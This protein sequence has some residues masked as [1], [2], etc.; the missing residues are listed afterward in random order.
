M[1]F[2]DALRRSG[3]WPDAPEMHPE[4]SRVC[5]VDIVSDETISTII[6]AQRLWAAELLDDSYLQV[7]EIKPYNPS[8]ISILRLMMSM[9]ALHPV[10]MQ[11]VEDNEEA[12]YSAVTAASYPRVGW[13]LQHFR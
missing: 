8:I 1:D 4:W 13:M 3:E 12:L 9:V 2:L 7:P 6:A 5:I 10:W 11:W